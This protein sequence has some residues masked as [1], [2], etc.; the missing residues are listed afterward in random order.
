MTEKGRDCSLRIP[1]EVNATEENNV[2]LANNNIDIRRN[3]NILATGRFSLETTEDF[4]PL[5]A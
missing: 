4:H 3:G 2:I 5:E 1:E